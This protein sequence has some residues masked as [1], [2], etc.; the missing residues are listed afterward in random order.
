MAAVRR[1]W[2]SLR[3]QFDGAGKHREVNM[4]KQKKETKK[5]ELKVRKLEKIETTVIREHFSA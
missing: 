2:T 3:I 5:L 1:F 4:E